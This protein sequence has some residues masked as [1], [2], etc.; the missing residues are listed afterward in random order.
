MIPELGNPWV[1]VLKLIPHF[2]LST[3]SLTVE[4]IGML[5]RGEDAA[6]FLEEAGDC[7]VYR[8]QRLMAAL[9]AGEVQG[10]PPRSRCARDVSAAVAR[11]R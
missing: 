3:I 5:T 10:D 1:R 8:V 7:A 11:R 9:G 2:M 6:T 4:D